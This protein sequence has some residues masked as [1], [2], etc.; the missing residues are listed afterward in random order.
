VP[1]ELLLTRPFVFDMNLRRPFMLTEM[2]TARPLFDAAFE[3]QMEIYAGPAFRAA[4]K[5]ELKQSRKW[6]GVVRNTSVVSVV[7]PEL[8]QC[9]GRT[10]GEIA[11]E[12]H[13]DPN[14]VFFDLAVADNR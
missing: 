11:D 13:Q 8:K 4:F 9:D 6:G 5:E 10:V 12:R 2:N 7:N 3:K 1:C 14:D